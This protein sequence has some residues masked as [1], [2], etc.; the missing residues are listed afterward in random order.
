MIATCNEKCAEA[1]KQ[2]IRDDAERLSREQAQAR[3]AAQMEAQEKEQAR[4]KAATHAVKMYA[5]CCLILL[6]LTS[7]TPLP[8][9]AALTTAIGLDVF[10]IIYIYKLYF[11]PVESEEDARR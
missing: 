2:K 6:C 5:L 11:A 9:W 7:W 4:D 1:K 3:K 10:P 8:L